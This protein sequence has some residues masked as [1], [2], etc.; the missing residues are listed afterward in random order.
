MRITVDRRT[1]TARRFTLDQ[2]DDALVL[3]LRGF[4]LIDGRPWPTRLDLRA[5]HRR[6]SIRLDRVEFAPPPPG[7]F[8]PPRRAKRVSQ[9]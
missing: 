4:R 3:E 1:R 9:P 6:A 5:G 7:A 2:G 8:D